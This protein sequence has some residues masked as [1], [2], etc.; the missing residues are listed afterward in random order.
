MLGEG[1]CTIFILFY[2]TETLRT[3][4]KARLL[5]EMDMGGWELDGDTRQEKIPDVGINDGL[6]AKR[7]VVD[8]YDFEVK[9]RTRMIFRSFLARCRA[10]IDQDA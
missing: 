3:L 1:D 8:C 6:L 5:G 2:V 4:S 7:F 9:I 10:A